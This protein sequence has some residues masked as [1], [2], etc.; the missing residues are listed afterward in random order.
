MKKKMK[1][2]QSPTC[3]RLRPTEKTAVFFFLFIADWLL[4]PSASL[5]TGGFLG[6]GYL[7]LRQDTLGWG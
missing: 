5:I 3:A 4:L 1:E 7:S 2:Q 6:A